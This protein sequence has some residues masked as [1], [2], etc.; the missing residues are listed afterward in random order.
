MALLNS[1]YSG[2]TGLRNQQTMLD[3]IGHNISNV[4]T[5]GYKGSRVT[6]S[7]TFNQLVKAGTNPTSNSGGT[8]SFQVGLGSKL[9]SIDRN[10][11]QGTFERTGIE[12]DLALQGPG[13]FILKINGQKNYT[14][15]GAFIFDSDGKLVNPQTGAVVQGKNASNGVVPPGN[16]LEDVKIDTT[17]KIPATATTQIK[18]GGN[19]KSS[20]AVTQTTVIKQEG[21]IKKDIDVG[22]Y[23]D[24]ATGAGTATQP[25]NG[26]TQK[27]YNKYGDEFTLHIFWKKTAANTWDV[28][29]KIKDKDGFDIKD[30]DGNV[31]TF[32]PVQDVKFNPTTGEMDTTADGG[33]VL[34]DGYNIVS[35]NNYID[36]NF[37][38][39]LDSSNVALIKEN[40][41]TAMA[42]SG[43]GANTGVSGSVVVY[44]SL[45]NS[46]TI[47]VKFAKSSTDNVW[48]WLAYVPG[49]STS[50]AKP[51]SAVGS[52]T[53]SSDGKLAV[54]NPSNPKLTFNPLGGAAPLNIDLNFG[55]NLTGITQTA[56]N[57]AVNALSQDGSP[58]SSLSNISID[59]YGVINGVFTNG[60][61]Q[62]LAQILVATFPNR[63]GLISVGGNMFQV[64]ANSGEPNVSE[65]GELSNTTVQ[66][67]TLEQSNVDLA[68]EFTKMII[69][70]RGFQANARVVTVSDQ[71]LQE[72]NN[73]VR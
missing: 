59:Q 55:T 20:S 70:Q 36:F 14:R 53:F 65:M 18:W 44:D 26:Y 45:G 6:F 46:H 24:P 39:D 22:Q 60:K 42:Q 28:E 49:T 17:L 9:N 71:I 27:F 10:W 69:S 4:N 66:S 2:V 58:A 62:A 5:I 61:T 63:N 48:E 3:V 38:V 16:N 33:L 43:D 34:K 72:L 50:N 21:T 64:A 19:L 54:V 52:V 37:K 41:S 32:N 11:N 15:A 47:T 12:T 30:A 57:S 23:L 29:F 67:G 1:L 51:A 13:L 68:E 25:T 35:D 31:I 8:N 56:S 40:S 7:E 73:I